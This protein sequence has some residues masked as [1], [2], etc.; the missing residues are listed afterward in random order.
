MAL[1]AGTTEGRL[2]AEALLQVGIETDVFVASEYGC[3]VLPK[4]SCLRI[5]VGRLTEEE[6]EEQFLTLHPDLILDAT[7]PY[8]ALVTDNIR[9]AGKRCGILY[10]RIRR[11]LDEEM[12]SA[13]HSSN[14]VEVESTEEAV[15]YLE[16]TSGN[17]FLTTGSKELPC[18]A[19]L[20]DYETRLYARVL[21]TSDVAS[22]CQNLGIK[23]RHLIMMQGPFS[24]EM[25]R[26]ML[27][28]SNAHY[29]VTKK[30]G[31]LGGF[32]EKC[33]AAMAVGATVVVIGAPK[34]AVETDEVLSLDAILQMIN[35]K[36]KE[37][38]RTICLIGMGPGNPDLISKEA[39]EAMRKA[40]VLIG[41][42][43]MVEMGLEALEC[44]K[45][46]FISYKP[47]EIRAFLEAHPDARR[48]AC[49]YSGDIDIYSGAQ[50]IRGIFSKDDEI[51]EIHGMSSV[52]AIAAVCG[53]QRNEIAIASVH[54]RAE[55]I[56]SLM[57]EQ[58]AAAV[59]L[60]GSASL[61]ALC[62]ELTEHQYSEKHDGYHLYLTL[63]ERLTYP[64]E[65][66]TQGTPEQ[67][68]TCNIDSLSIALIEWKEDQ[69]H[70]VRP[71]I[72]LA[73]PKSGGGKTTVT[74]GLIRALQRRNLTVSSF[75]CGPDY[76]DPMFHAATL[77][78]KSG[79]LD[80]FF[81]DPNT[82]RRIFLK[83]AAD[84]D[85][86]VI[87]GVMGYF[88]GLG[89][90]TERASSCEIAEITETP[91]I[92]IL[93]AKGA[94]VS[95]AAI[96]SGMLTFH[97]T[98]R[99]R[100]VILN[101][102]SG[103][104]YPRLKAALEEELKKRE[105]AIEILGYLPEDPAF[106]V[107]SRHLGLVSP[108]ELE[109]RRS[110]ADHIAET[111]EKCVDLDG[112]LRLAEGA[113]ALSAEKTD[114][115]DPN[116]TDTVRIAVAKDEA[117][118]FYY[119]ENEELLQEMGATLVYFSP[120]HDRHFPKDVDGLILGGGYPEL[121]SKELEANAVMRSEIRE[122]IEQG[123]PAIAECGG[124]LYLLKHLTGLDGASHEMCGMIDADSFETKRLVR[125]GYFEGTTKRDG[126]FGTAGCVL[127][128]HEFHYWDATDN[129]DGLAMKKPV[130][131][132]TWEAMVYTDTL[133]AGFPHFYY[134]GNPAAIRH[135][136]T[137][138]RKEKEKRHE[139]D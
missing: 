61:Q 22:I 120:V 46:T 13:E 103:M 24:K 76:I 25:N 131:D 78:V 16:G 75:K 125:F 59:L 99:I 115:A 62:R 35:G 34:E 112:I 64:D 111:I 96:L 12:G 83:R 114:H 67:F 44:R 50:G 126:L 48:I 106:Q 39:V 104:F 107:P 89:G 121:F 40:D 66:I 1:F 5:H 135:F 92:L 53:Y 38:H 23:G 27:K 122:R 20:S 133:A 132:R 124:F 130:G 91:V 37:D 17:I 69:K 26:L 109:D 4:G 73:A 19:A 55:D 11:A 31:S 139:R 80:S 41:A 52:D 127:R 97:E 6:M 2:I 101:R 63:G 3:D 49:L 98:T 117:F 102:V 87:E 65:V 45:D 9:T 116:E 42:R 21:P 33:E 60:G 28:E 18:F 79:N 136:L 128:G 95:L 71:R 30:S 82:L 51:I 56:A 118:S 47:D 72:M 10:R 74:C 108:A 85:I 100:G 77:G 70:T 105:V 86:S 36:K 68:F 93:D 88:D 8:A 57:E 137:R 29:L 81:T 123:L 113:G 7:H 129:G 14:Y 15:A 32:Q 43:R 58:H 54:G 90:T 138:C 119:A 110:W 84:T 94:S 134:P